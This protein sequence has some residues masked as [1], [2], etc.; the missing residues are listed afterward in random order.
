[1]ISRSILHVA[2]AFLC[3]DVFKNLS[4]QLVP[5]QD[6]AAFHF[7]P[8]NHFHSI[9]LF[10]QQGLKDYSESLFMLFH[11]AGH[12]MHYKNLSD[13]IE[14]EKLLQAPSGRSRMA[15]EQQ[16][17]DEA[18]LL[19]RRFLKRADLDEGELLPLFATYSRLCISSYSSGTEE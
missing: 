2:K 4:I 10:Y 16:A 11:E 13:P 18:L 17:W 3:W 8:Q 6:A 9:V 15:F 1:M 7:P 12:V 5:L 19:F 14:Y